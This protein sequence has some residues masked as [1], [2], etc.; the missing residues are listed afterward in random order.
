MNFRLGCHRPL[1]KPR[2]RRHHRPILR[3]GARFVVDGPEH[4]ILL[5]VIVEVVVDIELVRI[6]RTIEFLGSVD[7]RSCNRKNIHALPARPVEIDL[8]P[9]IRMTPIVG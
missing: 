2:H 4:Q 7:I 5:L 6:L 3:P 9:D 8:I 1:Q